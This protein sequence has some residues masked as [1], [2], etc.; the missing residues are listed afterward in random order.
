MT[1]RSQGRK[2][3]NFPAATAI[4]GSSFLDFFVNGTNFKISKADFIA[5]LGATGTIVQDGAVAG[6]P[7]L[8]VAGSVNNIRNIEDGSGI[9]SSVSPENGITIEHNFALDTVGVPLSNDFTLASPVFRSLIAGTGIAISG[10]GD[11]ITIGVST[12]PG[13]AKTVIVNSLDDFPSPVGSVITLEDET[14]YFLTND[15]NVGLNRFVFGN[16]TVVRGSDSSVITLTYTGTGIMFTA[17][18]AQCR[19]DKITLSCT[20]GTLL[21]ISDSTNLLL[22]QMIDMTVSSCDVVGTIDGYGAV[23]INNVAFANIITNGITFANPIGAFVGQT[24]IGIIQAGTIFDLGTAVIG[25]FSLESSLFTLVGAGTFLLDGLTGSGNITSTGLGVAVNN[26]IGGAGTPLNNIS[27]DDDQ[28]EFALNDDIRDTRTD[29]LI[30]LQGNATETVI[31]VS[32]TTVLIAGTWDTSATPSQFT[33][34]A[35]GRATYTGPKDARLPITASVTIEP[36]SGGSITVSACVAINGVVI[37]NSLRSS[38]A[39]AGS[40]TSI[41]VPWQETFEPTDFAEIFVANEDTTVNLIASSA[42][43]RIN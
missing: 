25:G 41:T 10:L 12:V 5:A 1:H 17:V 37:P 33:I 19:I 43:H 40:P 3:S 11:E 32:G 31:A 7:V 6:T 18:D 2:K 23:Q 26:R 29:A 30:S 42:I 9:Q 35:N 20:N 28:W 36:A 38:T 4:D 39:S 24:I 15:V 16:D 8:D 14:E 34:D 22:F 21:D 27:P 13:T